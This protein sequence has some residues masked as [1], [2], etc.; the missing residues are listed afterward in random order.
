MNVELIRDIRDFFHV[1]HHFLHF[2][3]FKTVSFISRQILTTLFK[4][5][6]FLLF[7]R[8]LEKSRH[9]SKTF[10]ISRKISTFLNN[11]QH[12]SSFSTIFD[13]FQWSSD[14]IYS[15][16]LSQAWS[17]VTAD[18]DTWCSCLVRIAIVA[19]LKKTISMGFSQSTAKCSITNPWHAR[20]WISCIW[21]Q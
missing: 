8:I 18:F 3:Y 14:I 4:F 9:F 5:F 6:I 12:F 19:S 10:V 17:S 7:S 13:N 1:F 11:T 21:N 20:N 15:F 16:L 2:L